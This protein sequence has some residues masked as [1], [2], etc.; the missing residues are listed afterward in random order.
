MLDPF[1]VPLLRRHAK[2]I[3]IQFALMDRSYQ[4]YGFAVGVPKY[5][6]D[7]EEVVVDDLT[8]NHGGVRKVHDKDI[9]THTLCK[10]VSRPSTLRP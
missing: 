6:E 10:F 7:V 9:Q 5:P 3:P 2:K 4:P 8:T 1:I